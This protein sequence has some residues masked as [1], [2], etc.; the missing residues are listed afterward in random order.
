[1]GKIKTNQMILFDEIYIVDQY[2]N[3]NLT[4][5]NVQS[6]TDDIF[7]V[8]YFVDILEVHQM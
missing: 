2:V 5:I 1:V 6:R 4:K 3:Y 8:F 7:Y